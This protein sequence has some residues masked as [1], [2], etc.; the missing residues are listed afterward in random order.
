MKPVPELDH[1]AA[2]AAR[3][4]WAA[5]AKPPGSLG[6]LEDVAVHLAAVTGSCPPPV[7][8]CPAVALF[9]G[10][11]GVVADGASAWPSDITAAM[12]A[13][14]AA[15][16]AAINA[17]ARTVGA[18]V[19][20]ID[21]GVAST[22]GLDVPAGGGDG[23][24]GV[25]GDGDGVEGGGSGPTGRALPV[26]DR[27]VRSGTA[28]IVHGSAM[29][30]DEAAR[31]IGVGSDQADRLI[32]GGADCLI[33]GEMGI[34]NTTPSAALISV[35]VGRSA[36]ELI[37][38]GAGVPVGGLAA[39]QRLV[40]VA[41][42]RA[43][44]AGVGPGSHPVELMA[45]LGGLEIAALAGFQIGAARR[46]VP[47]IVDGVIALAALCV[48]DRLAP[49]TAARALAGHRSTEPAASAAL[50]HLDLDPLLDLRL[51]LGEG[52]GATL[53]FSL[54]AAGARALAE[55][56]DLPGPPGRSGNVGLGA[57]G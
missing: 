3:Y 7:P 4:R 43:T 57:A 20:V 37:G 25:D 35:C 2:E 41:I 11:H 53:A 36:S 39:K 21:V 38:P 55:M 16:G 40:E 42:E 22:P 13:T 51:R 19:T 54:V 18:E 50:S 30:V 47:F 48:A 10:D 8:V 52:T 33:G 29:T 12:V 9:A 14:I 49:G 15:G 1:E 24:D 46:R 26:L 23:V 5:R 44:A 28:S 34:G 6:R 56:A 32:D 31:A 27:R 45:Q 17:I